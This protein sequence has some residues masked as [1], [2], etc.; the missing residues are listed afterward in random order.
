MPTGCR[1]TLSW[2]TIRFRSFERHSTNYESWISKSSYPSWISTWSHEAAGGPKAASIETNWRH[3]IL[4]RTAFPT[5]FSRSKSEQYVELFRLFD[6]YSD[7][8]ERV[9][10]W[11]L[12]DGQS[13]LNDFPWRRVNYPLLFDRNRRPKPAFDAVYELLRTTQR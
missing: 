13:W 3:T 10:F 8:I 12:H 6:E 5:R 1:A 11:N 2:A 4:T 9:S 7:I